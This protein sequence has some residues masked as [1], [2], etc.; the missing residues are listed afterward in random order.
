MPLPE[1]NWLWGDPAEILDR[2]RAMQARA[3]EAERTKKERLRLKKS[4]RIKQL[5]KK[6][7]NRQLKGQG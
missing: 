4:R 6:A 5:L 2:K 1:Y 3:D 7:K